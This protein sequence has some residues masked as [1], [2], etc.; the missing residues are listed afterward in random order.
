M[1]KLTSSLEKLEIIITAIPGFNNI[2]AYFAIQQRLFNTIR[3]G[4]LE[5]VK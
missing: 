3:D 4:D 1:A 2:D 5:S